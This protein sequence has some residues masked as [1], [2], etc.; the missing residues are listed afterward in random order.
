[1]KEANDE[2]TK[3]TNALVAS[4]EEDVTRKV[5]KEVAKVTHET[6]S[7]P[8]EVTKE[9]AQGKMKVIIKC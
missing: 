9:A 3:A 7:K 5:A 8:N 6:T 4:K 2:A 1:M